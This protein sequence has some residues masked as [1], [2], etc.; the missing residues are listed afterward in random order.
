MY[1][2]NF[3][4]FNGIHPIVSNISPYLSLCHSLTHS[5]AYAH[6]HTHTHSLSLSL[7]TVQNIAFILFISMLHVLINVT[8]HRMF[9]TNPQN[10]GKML[11]FWI[12][13]KYYKI[14]ILLQ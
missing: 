14:Y 2:Q 8:H 7:C 11:L 4:G 6:T 5:H 1:K 13:L 12:S 9:Y 3:Y 10:Q